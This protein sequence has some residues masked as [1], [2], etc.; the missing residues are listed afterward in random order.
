MAPRSSTTGGVDPADAEVAQ[1]VRMKRRA[2][3]QDG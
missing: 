2:I 1:P 3:L